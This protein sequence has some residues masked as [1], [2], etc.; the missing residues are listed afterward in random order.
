MGFLVENHDDTDKLIFAATAERGDVL[1]QAEHC[2]ALR[3]AGAGKG[4][5]EYLCMSV[6]PYVLDSWLIRHGITYAEFM[7]DQKLQTRFVEDPDNAAFRV[8]EGRL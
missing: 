6:H 4:K 5:D 2:A 3:S 8:W 1:A 7:R